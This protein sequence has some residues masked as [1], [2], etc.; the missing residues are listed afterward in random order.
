M[1]MIC[2]KKEKKHDPETQH[3][4]NETSSQTVY[5]FWFH[6]KRSGTIDQR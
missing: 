6:S 5:L 3:I 2:G 4:F 1:R